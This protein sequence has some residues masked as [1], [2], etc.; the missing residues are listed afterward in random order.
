MGGK[1]FIPPETDGAA[2]VSRFCY[3]LSFGMKS[4]SDFRKYAGLASEV[5]AGGETVMELAG[6]L[7]EQWTPRFRR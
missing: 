6:N 5:S 4:V 2:Q 1:D 3:I 7:I